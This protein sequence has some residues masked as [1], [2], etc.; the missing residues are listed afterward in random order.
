M[1]LTDFARRYGGNSG[2]RQLMEDLGA[3]LEGASDALML[4][5]GNPSHIPAVQALFRD[6]LAA[7]AADARLFARVFGDYDSPQGHR[8]FV[9]AIAALLK[10]EYGWSLTRRN[11]AL[12]HGSQSAF[13]LLFNMF[14]GVSQPRPRRILLPMAPEY[15]GY[16]DLG[17]REGM[18]VAQRPE[19]ELLD[20]DLFKYHV[21]LRHLDPGEDI[22][23]ICVSRPT[24][25]TGNVIADEE[26]AGLIA[27]ARQRDIPLIVDGA[28]GMPFPAIVFTEARPVWN[29]HVI[30]CL[31]L[32]KLGL[33]G[34]RTGVVIASEPIIDALTGMNAILHLA[35]GSV[36][37]ALALDSVASGD[38]L[39]I[40]RELVNPFYRL[41]AARAL[42]R[43]REALKGCEFRIHRPEGAFFLWLWFPGLPVSA[44]GLYERL[45]ARGV[46]VLPGHHFFP[47]LAGPWQHTQECL[48]VSYT[49]EDE[50]VERG[51]GII[52]EEVRRAWASP[53]AQGL[54][55][56][57]SG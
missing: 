38:I 23:A 50:T 15:I 27:M 34:V 51:I 36:G 13:F 49:A 39:R 41:K 10:R 55:Q 25:P 32:S 7:I 45:K 4:G 9:A 2:T 44:A 28:Y 12:T 26:M 33:P 54:S 3:A 52:A 6:R 42:A 47:G 53:E 19:I 30:L 22:G 31:S 16:S 20:E 56:R 57:W 48:R 17:M 21:D 5:G 11:I 46:I 35:T 24:N 37:P 18:F 29:E 40:S 1:T 43:A 14:A 8:E